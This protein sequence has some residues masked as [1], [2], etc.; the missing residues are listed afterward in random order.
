MAEMR[1]EDLA[2]K[3]QE[4]EK[5]I[6][7]ELLGQISAHRILLEMLI[8]A[9]SEKGTPKVINQML[10]EG[11]FDAYLGKFY[12]F[13]ME[14]KHQVSAETIVHLREEFLSIINLSIIGRE[15]E[16][17]RKPPT[18]RRRFLDWLERG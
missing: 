5:R 10:H 18:L 14:S 16:Q 9:A 7:E 17:S 2:R 13:G 1:N 15:E 4:L 6:T 11:K 3:V 12:S 8:S